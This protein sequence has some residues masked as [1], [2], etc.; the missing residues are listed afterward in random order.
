MKKTTIASMGPRSRERGVLKEFGPS[1]QFEVMLQWGR[2]HVSA[3]CSLKVIGLE[4]SGFAS[5]GPRSRERG[6]MRDVNNRVKLSLASM[7]PRSCERGVSP[8][9]R[10]SGKSPITLLW[11]RSRV[12][13]ECC[14]RGMI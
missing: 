9:H 14:P 13:G 12:S 3:E 7:G 11:A 2:A 10:D 8:R 6:V 1:E 4:H 5:M